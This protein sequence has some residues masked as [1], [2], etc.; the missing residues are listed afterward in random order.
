MKLGYVLFMTT[1]LFGSSTLAERSKEEIR[2]SKVIRYCHIAW[3]GES[4]KSSRVGPEVELANEFS[5][6]LGLKSESKIVLW[7]DFFK[8]D[9]N[10]VR[11]EQVY[12]PKLL[13]SS[14]C[15]FYAANMT[16]TDWRQ[17]KLTIVPYHAGRIMIV[18]RKSD[19]GRFRR[20]EDLRGKK[21]IATANSTLL[22]E[23]ENVNKDLKVSGKPFEIM[24]TQTGGTD[25]A[26]LAG[27]VDFIALDTSQAL[28]IINKSGGAVSIAFTIGDNQSIGWA[29]PKSATWLQEQFAEFVR[30]QKT[31]ERSPMNRIFESYYGVTLLRYQQIVHNAQANL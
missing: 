14:Q 21:T 1:V 16:V 25:K 30:K 28:Q 12:V 10:E 29:F 27:V 11:K 3:F 15:D 8:D 26:L 23:L 2:A 6:F 4:G 24:K 22:A 13:A 5:K 18:A 19:A 31:D 7:N 20:A 17:T 9:S